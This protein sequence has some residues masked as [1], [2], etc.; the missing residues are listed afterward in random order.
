MNTVQDHPFTFHFM[1]N[2][3]VVGFRSKEGNAGISVLTLDGIEIPYS[4]IHDTASRNTRLVLMVQDTQTLSEEI[5]KY[6]GGNN[7]LTIQV[8]KGKA[9]D[10]ETYRPFCLCG[11][12]PKTS[13]S[14]TPS[15]A[16]RRISGYPLPP[17]PSHHRS[18]RL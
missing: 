11:S 4:Q 16:R 5:R 9:L 18:N 6:L 3:N 7:A 15:K 1:Q 2:G 12:S 13:F 10:L 8:P 14:F 17:L